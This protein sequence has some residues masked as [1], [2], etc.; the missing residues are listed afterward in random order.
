MK[1]TPLESNLNE[2]AL[3]D[4]DELMHRHIHPVVWAENKGRP[5]SSAF[6]PKAGERRLSVDRGSLVSPE[7]SFRRFCVSGRESVGVWSVTVGEYRARHLLCYPEPRPDN[8]AHAGVDF[9]DVPQTKT[10]GKHLAE[11]AQRRGPWR[12]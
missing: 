4:D 2:E 10:L 5:N 1:P 7:E 3:G 6:L 8:D 9:G 11:L 12:P